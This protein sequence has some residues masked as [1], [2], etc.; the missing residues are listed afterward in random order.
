MPPPP[1]PGGPP[2]FPP[3]SMPAGMMMPPPGMMMRPQMLPPPGMMPPGPSRCLIAASTWSKRRAW[4]FV[5]WHAGLHSLVACGPNVA[6]PTLT[7]MHVSLLVCL[8]EVLKAPSTPFCASTLTLFQPFCPCYLVVSARPC[9]LLP[10]TVKFKTLS[11]MFTLPIERCA[12]LDGCRHVY[13]TTAHAA[14]TSASDTAG[15]NAATQ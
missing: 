10:S 3:G 9:L 2:G 1:R 4:R 11:A 8:R 13:A 7:F 6:E 12:A 5:L 14:D 15:A